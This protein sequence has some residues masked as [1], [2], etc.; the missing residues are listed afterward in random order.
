MDMQCEYHDGDDGGVECTPDYHKFTRRVPVE[1]PAVDMHV[2]TDYDD[3]AATIASS[4]LSHARG[5][6]NIVPEESRVMFGM[7]CW[8]DG[9]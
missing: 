7:L 8:N 1:T 9:W 5:S 2:E 3:V 6:G 4:S